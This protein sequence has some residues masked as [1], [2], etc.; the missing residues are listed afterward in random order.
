M[1]RKAH[2]G[3]EAGDSARSFR[4][5]V[6]LGFVSRSVTYGVIGAL[7]LALALGAG[8]AGAAANQQG[9]LDLIARSWP[10]RVA[11]VAIAAG[12][13]AYAVWKVTQGVLGSGPEGGGGASVRDR[14][15][16]TTAGL[17]YLVFFAVAVRAL[18]G[19]S[20]SKGKPEQAT[21]DVLSWPGGEVVVAAA[22]VILV[23]VSLYQLYEGA[24]GKFAEE[25]K[26]AGMRA[27]QRRLF[28][29]VGRIGISSRA[30]VFALIGYLLVRA[31]IDVNPNKAVGI[32]GALARVHRE[33]A[34]NLLLAFVAAGLLA[35]AVFSLV[36]GR[37]RRL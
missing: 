16:S 9:A 32:G 3:S 33:P 6:R 30:L 25:S 5:L 11:L 2:T 35:F 19:G 15:A 12:L 26:T 14:V 8:T 37:Y 36:E 17:A 18:V 4:W 27:N 13:L 23:A 22:G 34:G 20:S 24:S 7:A 10:G 29:A 21:A 1:T 31:A 28:M